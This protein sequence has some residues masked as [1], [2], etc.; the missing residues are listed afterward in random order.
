[1]ACDRTDLTVTIVRLAV[2]VLMERNNGQENQRQNGN[3]QAL[4][5]FI[6]G[7]A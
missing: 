3:D 1:M 6:T 2:N 4:K 5:C 7:K